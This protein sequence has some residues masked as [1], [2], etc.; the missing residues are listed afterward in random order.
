ME[1]TMKKLLE[2]VGSRECREY[3]HTTFIL[4]SRSNSSNQTKHA[5]FWTV[6][7][8]TWR[9]ALQT[10]GEH[11]NSTQKGLLTSH[12]ATVLPGQYTSYSLACSGPGSVEWA[13]RRR[14]AWPRWLWRSCLWGEAPPPVWEGW[15]TLQGDTQDDRR[16]SR[17]S[18]QSFF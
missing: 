7:E 11:A 15:D 8:R 17:D 16:W 12:W 18:A 2:A 5:Y 3:K 1:N 6:E 9:K 10:W 4:T 13:S 14:P